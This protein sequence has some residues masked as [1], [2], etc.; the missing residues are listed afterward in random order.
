MKVRQESVMFL[1][2]KCS[3]IVNIFPAFHGLIYDDALYEF[4]YFYLIL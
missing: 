4:D 2:L 3:T 1:I